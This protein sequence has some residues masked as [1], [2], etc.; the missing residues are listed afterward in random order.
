MKKNTILI[1]I[2]LTLFPAFVFAQ[3]PAHYYDAARGKKGETLKEALH[4]IISNC[5]SIT[6]KQ[7][8]NAFKLTDVDEN[9]HIID[10]YSDIP[11]GTPAYVY[12]FGSDQ[13]GDYNSEGDCYN[14]EHSVPKSWF[15]D[16][17]PMYSDIFHLYPTDGWV[18][19]KRGNRALGEVSDATYTSSNG[20]KIGL[21][22]Y[23]GAPN[24]EVFEPIDEYKGDLART[25]FFMSLRYP[26]V[27]FS[28]EANSMYSG[29]AL[30]AWALAMLTDWHEADPV[31]E[32][33]IRRNNA[34]FDSIQFNRNPFIDHPELV[35]FLWGDSVNVVWQPAADTTAPIDPIEPTSIRD[36]A[37]PQHQLFP[38]PTTTE[39][40][41]SN[42]QHNITKIEIFDEVGKLVKAVSAPNESSI[43]LNISNLESG[44]YFVKIVEPQRTETH[45]LIIF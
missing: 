27:N 28:Q 25:Y 21:N 33:E 9:G 14:R 16:A 45:K 39:L 4:E 43:Y 40:T 29:S 10:I 15:N 8:W 19:N 23:P 31:S 7:L 3:A 38:N 37:A 6:Y 2:F 44:I 22:S 32:K 34:I 35:A 20:S 42:P 5:E 1:Y 41:I 11:G 13:C 17:A 26:D 18:N 12:T 24:A 30:K 36:D